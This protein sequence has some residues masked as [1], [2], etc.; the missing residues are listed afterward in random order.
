[1]SVNEIDVNV[2]NARTKAQLDSNDL[3]TEIHHVCA[4]CGITAN[5]ST[6]IQKYGRPPKKLALVSTF[7]E[8][9]CDFCEEQKFVTE[10]RN[11]FYPDFGLI[12]KAAKRMG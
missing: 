6:C 11:F 1:M 10:V 7:H 8:G 9:T 5:V 2:V 4:E 3:K 12:E